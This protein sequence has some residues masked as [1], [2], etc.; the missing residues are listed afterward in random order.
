MGPTCTGK[1]ALGIEV[2]KKFNGEIIN[3]DSMQ[4]YKG[5]D[6]GTDKVP[7]TLRKEVKHH[8]LDIA[9]HTQQFT[10]AD[11]AKLAKQ[12]IDDISSRGKLPIVVGGTGLYIRA[13]LNGI[14]PGPGRDE[15]IRAKL[16]KEAKEKGLN[17]LRKKLEEIDPAY[18]Q[19]IGENDEMRIIRALEVYYLTGKPISEHFKNTH[20]QVNNFHK[21]KIG[22][23]L[24]RKEL[25][26]RINER[27]ERM[28]TSGMV[29]EVKK[30]LEQGV[31]PQS[32]PFKALGYK[33][34]LKVAQGKMS[35]KEA[36]SLTQKETRRYAKRQIIWFRKDKDIKWF[37]SYEKEKIF[38]FIEKE[39]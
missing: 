22:L 17:Y 29:N 15:T 18:A 6:I 38:N 36:I 28:F 9:D 5:F 16:K 31:D 12:A 19:I 33:Y 35:E 25:Y 32:P 27:V 39:L 21:I 2:A 24:D 37:S 8:L 7:P 14:F 20:S 34:A 23:I 3:C 11:F 13:L 26:R 1:S 30:L 10:A 4:V